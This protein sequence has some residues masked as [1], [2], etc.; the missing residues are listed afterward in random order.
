MQDLIPWRREYKWVAGE[1]GILDDGKATGKGVKVG[2]KVGDTG[3]PA[4]STES[5]VWGL[6]PNH[7]GP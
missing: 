2:L 6:E 7:G 5:T 4:D 3:N 1:E